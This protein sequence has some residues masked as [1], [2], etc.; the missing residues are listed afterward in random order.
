MP[1][2]YRKHNFGHTRFVL[3]QRS[4]ARWDCES[5][6]FARLR[7]GHPVYER[8][9][10]DWQDEDN[11]RCATV[12]AEV[13]LSLNAKLETIRQRRLAALAKEEVQDSGG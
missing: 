12:S 13:L 5:S 4:G 7:P 1:V 9:K 8:L 6:H 10:R 11:A 2:T 3:Q